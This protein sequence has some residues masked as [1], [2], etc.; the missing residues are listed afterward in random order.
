MAAKHSTP[1]KIPHLPHF[2]DGRKSAGA[3]PADADSNIV[4]RLNVSW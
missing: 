4:W 1:P 2:P 3:P